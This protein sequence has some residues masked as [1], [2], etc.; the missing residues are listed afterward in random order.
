MKGKTEYTL[1]AHVAHALSSQS[2]PKNSSELFS[3]EVSDLIP[4]LFVFLG[5]HV[6]KLLRFASNFVYFCCLVFLA[7]P[8]NHIHNSHFSSSFFQV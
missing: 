5:V 2:K 1:A 4:R 7:I 8:L 3:A 6:R